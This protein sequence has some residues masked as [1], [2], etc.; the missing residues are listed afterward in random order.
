MHV[1]D[2]CKPGRFWG[3]VYKEI[4]I[5]MLLLGIKLHHVSK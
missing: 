1:K 2:V 3:T 5:A 4:G